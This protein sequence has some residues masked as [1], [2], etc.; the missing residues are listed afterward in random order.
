MTMLATEMID[1]Y[2]ASKPPDADLTVL[3][4]VDPDDNECSDPVFMGHFD[5]SGW[6]D[7]HCMPV[8]VIA[9][10]EIPKGTRG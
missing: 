8:E 6:L 1:W 3:I 2:P 7:V 10:A 4:E 5:G 9:W